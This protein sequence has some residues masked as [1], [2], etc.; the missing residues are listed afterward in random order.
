MGFLQ[1]KHLCTI[2]GLETIG[3]RTILYNRLLSYFNKNN[4][5]R[6]V[7]NNHSN[8][9]L[10]VI[11]ESPTNTKNSNSNNINNIID[12]NGNRIQNINQNIHNNKNMN[13][14][15]NSN[16]KWHKRFKISRHKSN[17]NIQMTSRSKSNNIQ[18]AQM[19]DHNDN[20]NDNINNT[21]A[22]NGTILNR[23]SVIILAGVRN[24]TVLYIKMIVTVIMTT[25]ITIILRVRV[26]Q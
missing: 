11:V 13:S 3:N 17:N 6:Y 19:N 18:I 8:A 22:N 24:R 1:L 10:D 14:V 16:K 2:Y 25:I 7:T 23:K 12:N 21:N 20:N 15:N 4:N 9:Q 5:A 26:N